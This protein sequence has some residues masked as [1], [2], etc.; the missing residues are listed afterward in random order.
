MNEEKAHDEVLEIVGN[1]SW[2]SF[3]A[4]FILIP[5]TLAGDLIINVLAVHSKLPAY[6]C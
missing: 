1:F 6:E 2:F 3:I 5:T 4:I